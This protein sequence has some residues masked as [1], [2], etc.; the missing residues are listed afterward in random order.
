MSRLF[1]SRI[2]QTKYL[3]YYLSDE[4][5]CSYTYATTLHRL[6]EQ[7]TEIHLKLQIIFVL[8]TIFVTQPIKN[9]KTNIPKAGILIVL[10]CSLCDI[11]LF[12]IY[13]VAVVTIHHMQPYAYT[14]FLQSHHSDILLVLLD[15]PYKQ[16]IVN[17]KHLCNSYL[18]RK[19]ICFNTHPPFY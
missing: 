19:R 16:S 11:Q 13:V 14:T 7:M 9:T 5:L 8:H 18:K 2:F 15:I 12:S 10:P 4:K 6:Q 3:H 1:A 17:S